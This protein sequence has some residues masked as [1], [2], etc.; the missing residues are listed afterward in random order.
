[1]M[2][3]SVMAVLLQLGAFGQS[4]EQS[5]ENPP[6]SARP[7]TFW[8]RTNGNV[9]REGI[10]KD[11]EGMKAV[12]IGGVITFRLSG[13]KWAPPGPLKTGIEHQLPMIR[14]A[15][16][17]AQRLGIAF[18]LVIDYGYGSG[19]PHITPDYSM[20]QLY[21]SET[22]VQGGRTI[23]M[24][25][26]RPNLEPTKAL[27]LEKVWLRPG[28]ELSPGVTE[29]F[30][31]IDSYRDVAVFA[32]PS[33]FG[34]SISNIEDLNGLSWKTPVQP[35]KK[36]AAALPRSRI[37]T[38]T[39]HMGADG[40]LTWDAPKGAWT[41][42][43]LGYAS[44]FKLSRPCPAPEV[45]LECDRLH[46][47]GIDKHFDHRLKPVLEAM[48]EK[49]LI[50]YI[51]IDSWEAHSQNWTEGFAD[52]FRRRCGYD[53]LPWLPVLTGRVIES[54]DKS[55]RFLWDFRQAIGEVMLSNYI[56]RLEERLKPYGTKLFFE[57]YG[58]MCADTFT[59]AGRGAFPVGEFWSKD[60][61]IP[62]ITGQPA[63]IDRKWNLT[64]KGF[65]S[66]ANTYG[67]PCVG[68][69]AFTGQRGWSDHPYLIKGMGDYA[70]SEGV[71]R[72]V[73][74]LSVH[75]PYDN[76]RPGFTHRKWG[77]H[78]DRHQT[79]W[80]FS[81][82]YL[83][84]VARCQ[85]LLQKGHRVAD[86]A[87]LLNEGSPLY[88]RYLE[89]EF[90]ADHDYDICSPE[91]IQRMRV[92]QGRI[93]LP[94]GVLYRYL[95]VVP[96]QLTLPTAMKIEELRKAGAKVYTRSPIKGSPSL[97]GYPEAD[98]RVRDVAG[99]WPVLPAGGWSSVFAEDQCLPDFE[100]GAIC[101][102]H[103]RTTDA[104]IYFVANTAY[105][106]T[107]QECVFRTDHRAAELWSPETG[108]RFELPCERDADGRM[109]ASIAFGPAQSWFVVF[110]KKST[111]SRKTPCPEFGPV[112][113]IEGPWRLEFDPEW[114]TDRRLVLQSLTSW[115]DHKDP[116][117]K[118]YSGTAS[119]RTEF[120][121]SEAQMANHQSSM[122]IDLGR[123]E[124]MAQ[125]IL[126][127]KNLG[128]VWKPPYRLE[129][130]DALRAG[131]NA[132]EIRVVNTWANRLIGDEQLPLDSEWKDWET[133]L[134]YPDWFPHTDRRP[135]G[136]YTF[137]TA[138]HYK[139]GSML[140]TSGLLG[141]VQLLEQE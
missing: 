134:G 44:N 32:F 129:V 39:E 36:G 78:F 20:Q 57:P 128:I 139:K 23:S 123:V 100:G 59:W 26:P 82:P 22:D 58:S 98:N 108:E 110:R 130:A 70:F 48:K 40:T 65:A 41:V 119:Y 28:A 86:V 115:T 50:D 17:E 107:R 19:G 84:Y 94:T 74:H 111:A 10:T 14:W 64:M 120:E 138:R 135:S 83:T 24:K 71:S 25:L 5:F 118:Y 79:W 53:P 38:L 106:A 11:L 102:L 33:S 4:L 29:D 13:P 116:L 54:A 75:Q 69:E 8:H 96:T 46:P 132:L 136:R 30:D 49:Q 80:S 31:R 62:K 35:L 137:T 27:Q 68:A 85:A 18:S 104:D 117:V 52:E 114:G 66:I 16:E 95:E 42:V 99:A 12:G 91:I 93:V 73:Y 55:E 47:R 126:N 140:Q 77:Q 34:P 101:W 9:T 109:R 127:G 124:V 2:L 1:M 45:G 89:H 51:F 112:Q 3:A 141:P 76:V 21:Q 87:I 63:E 60:R 37:I 90:P 6:D 97:S 121:L 92:D 88:I 72:Y 125:V 103:R 131:K 105:E 67:K 113:T 43:R 122:A 7:W 81:K 56:D 61:R 133:L 15:A